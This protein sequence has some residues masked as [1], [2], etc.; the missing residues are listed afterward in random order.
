MKTQDFL[1]KKM[2]PFHKKKNK[3]GDK[4]IEL[5][6]KKIKIQILGL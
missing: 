2:F 1:T 4:V 6:R 5:I 3:K